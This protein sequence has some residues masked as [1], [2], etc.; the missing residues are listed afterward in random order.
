M[1]EIDLMITSIIWNFFSESLNKKNKFFFSIWKTS[2]INIQYIGN[3]LKICGFLFLFLFLLNSAKGRLFWF[4]CHPEISQ[5]FFLRTLHLQSEL[6][7]F[8]LLST[9]SEFHF[10]VL[11]P[12]CTLPEE[13]RKSKILHPV[14][15][16]IKPSE[17]QFWVLKD[18]I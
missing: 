5:V 7:R 1:A 4:P 2:V 12:R 9:S 13:T 8:D 14:H 15:N 6:L 16:K 11:L 18:Q 3:H 17:I 10:Y